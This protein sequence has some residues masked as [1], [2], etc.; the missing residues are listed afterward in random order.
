MSPNSA[1]WICCSDSSDLV[2][3]PEAKSLSWRVFNSPISDL[4]LSFGILICKLKYKL[5]LK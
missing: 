5:G 1:R 4:D 3:L 2:D